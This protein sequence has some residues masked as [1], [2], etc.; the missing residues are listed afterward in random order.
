M[1]QTLTDAQLSHR[2]AQLVTDFCQATQPGDRVLISGDAAAPM[3]DLAAATAA[4]GAIPVIDADTEVAAEIMQ[5]GP[6][7]DGRDA[8]SQLA[9]WQDLTGYV[10]IRTG[11]G[12]A[13]APRPPA[14]ELALIRRLRMTL[15]KTTT[16][17][18]DQLLAD[19]AGMTLP[20]LKDHYARL[21]YLDRD[22]PVSGFRELEQ[23]QADRI[24]VL[25][26]SSTIRIRG[27]RTELTLEV[28]GRGWQNSYG[29]RNT[30]SGEM[31]TSPLETS[32]NGI[33]Y[34]DVPSYNFRQPVSGVQLEFRDGVVTGATAEQGEDVLHRAL[35]RDEGAR[36]LGEIGIG[37]N[38]L[39]TRPLGST[40]FDEKI[41]GTVH[42]A[43]GASYPQTGGLNE[44]S[45][46][47][48]LIK[49]L[50]RSGEILLDGEPFQVDGQ[51][52]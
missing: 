21:L 32:A 2:F 31:F 27:A 1:K 38:R 16:Y 6:Y 45:L 23:F 10:I 12:R 33:I 46:H 22:D 13:A 19:R 5:A 20:E 49:D 28:S 50:R 17:W 29:R 51:F 41:A 8:A 26:R 35:E 39:M 18:P 9:M 30:P 4:A 7:E 42:L 36:R 25:E 37:G 34:F 14:D 44:S 47:W 3:R 52:V 48:D 40:L 11:A 15:R 24:R 43:L